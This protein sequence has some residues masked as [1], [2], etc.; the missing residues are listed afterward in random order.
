MQPIVAIVGPTGT[1]KTELA[2]SIAKQVGAV[3]LPL[4]Q[5]HRYA[6]LSEGTGLDVEG[7]SQVDHHG[8]QILSPWE[9]SGPEKYVQWLGPVLSSVGIQRPV[10]LEGGCTSYLYKILAR[11]DDQILKKIRIV[12][13]ASDP[14][15]PANLQR[16]RDRWSPEKILAVIE[17]T[18]NLEEEKFICGAGLPLLELCERLWKHPENDDPTLAWAIRISAR[19]YGP[20]Y[21]ALRGQLSAEMARERIVS[22]VLDIQRY[23]EARIRSVLPSERIFEGSQTRQLFSDICRFLLE[24]REPLNAE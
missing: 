4:D 9:V 23:Q 12:A 3:L 14:I 21:L 13:L 2:I 15:G 20:S 17:E 16:I 18:K 6:H 10:V 19:I 7:L 1:G 11:T 8:Y 5:L 22:N 24:N